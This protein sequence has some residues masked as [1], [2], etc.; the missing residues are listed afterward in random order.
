L[1]VAEV[2]AILTCIYEC[3]T[4][5]TTAQ[6]VAWVIVDVATHTLACPV[7]GVYEITGLISV[8]KC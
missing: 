5:S 2:D 7:A 1:V 8:G 4:A 3:P 6:D